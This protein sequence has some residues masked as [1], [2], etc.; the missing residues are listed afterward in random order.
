MPRTA[1]ISSFCAVALSTACGGDVGTASFGTSGPTSGVGEGSSAAVETGSSTHGFEPTTDADEPGTTTHTEPPEPLCDVISVPL[2]VDRDAAIH[3]ELERERLRTFFDDLVAQTGA[4]VRIFPNGAAPAPPFWLCLQG[5]DE[6]AG[7]RTFV[8]GE[9]FVSNPDGPAILDCVLDGV[10]DA[11]YLEGGDWLFTGLM[12]PILDHGD[13]PTPDADLTVALLLGHTDDRQG[14]MFARPGM[15]S[16]AYI[17]LAGAHD[18]RRVAA[19]AIGEGADKLH[20]FTL[21][22]GETSAYYDWAQTDLSAALDAFAPLA[23]RACAEHDAPSP[24]E[25][26]GG[27]EHID[28]LLVVDGSASMGEEQAALRGDGDEPPVFAEFTDALESRLDTLLDIHVGVVSSEPGDTVLHTHANQ[29]SVPPSIATDCG[30]PPGQRYLVGPSPTFEQDFACLASTHSDQFVERTAQNAALALHD[31][32]NAGFLRDDAVLFV[33][34]VT[35]EDTQDTISRVK[36]RELILDAVD[37]RLERLVVLA[38]AGDQG[39]FEMPKSTCWDGVY[40][41]AAPGRRITSIVHSFREQG[42][43]QDICAGDF[44]TVFTEALEEVVHTCQHLHPPG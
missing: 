43:V 30:L 31:P 29:P 25:L 41:S 35:D 28:I 17:R 12:M 26:P 23:V 44:T 33:V 9:N 18:P 38:I 27:C 4:E 14:G 13:W 10:R 19:F 21:S 36:V 1:S 20:T 15:T 6:V 11:T 2:V 39:V 3:G 24:P 32:A 16:E 22:L 34:L 7:G 5:S 42:K 8:W 40:G 37:G